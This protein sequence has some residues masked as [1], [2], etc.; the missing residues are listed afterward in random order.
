MVVP[1]F[2]I[3]LEPWPDPGG[4]SLSGMFE[5]A[6]FSAQRPNAVFRED[7]RCIFSG[8]PKSGDQPKIIPERE[9]PPA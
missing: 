3:T 5:P 7:V 8:R 1:H 4:R 9:E 2:A 6:G